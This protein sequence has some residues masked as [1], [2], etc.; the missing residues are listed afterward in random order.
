V[1]NIKKYGLYHP[2]HVGVVATAEKVMTGGSISGL[3]T[4]VVAPIMLIGLVGYITETV[5]NNACNTQFIM[6][7]A[8]GT[9]TVL[10]A[11][12][13]IKQDVI[14]GFWWI[15]GLKAD[16]L[17]N[18]VPGTSLP[19]GMVALDGT[20]VHP[21]ILPVGAIDLSLANSNP[22]TGKV[23]WYLRYAPLGPDADVIGS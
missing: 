22:T 7:P 1:N 20:A 14:G 19:S 17:V 21:K 23:I 2:A 8:V 16:A 13:D 11:V 5:S 6:N 3:F 10:C 15:T 12:L 4:I 18:A 9:S